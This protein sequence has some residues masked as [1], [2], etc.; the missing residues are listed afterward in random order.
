MSPVNLPHGAGWYNSFRGSPT[1]RG[2]FGAGRLAGVRRGW[3]RCGVKP[4]IRA[5]VLVALATALGTIL[6][7][8]V[9]VT[10]L[11]GAADFPYW[12]EAARMLRAGQNPYQLIAPGGPP[13]YHDN[14]FV[15][16]ITAAV[17]TLPWSWLPVYVGSALFSAVGMGV[18]AFGIT[19]ENWN[20][21]PG[22]MSFP[23][24][25]AISSGQWSPWVTAAALFPWLGCFGA[26]KPTL[27][28]AAFLYR[29]R[30]EYVASGLAICLLGFLFMPSW[31]WQWV[32]NTHRSL[33]GNYHVPILVPGG[34]I[35][36]LA[37]LRWRRP[38]ARLLLA[39][40]CVPQTP[41]PYDQLA[42]ILVPNTRYQSYVFAIWSYIALFLARVPA[43]HIEGKVASF[44]YLAYVVTFAYYLPLVILILRR[45]NRESD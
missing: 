29:L 28:V 23:V 30:W 1:T 21:W 22:L 9:K 15:Y 5:R 13:F 43:G 38:E 25:W 3:E 20:R 2:P 31:P 33:A 17:A 36:A 44:R 39:M 42:L 40:A 16:P 6:I 14:V 32:A 10:Q 37:A 45:P 18:L 12:W 19:R 11:Q 24:L 27:G 4:T 35:L 26:C 7:A 8:A 34:A 41:L